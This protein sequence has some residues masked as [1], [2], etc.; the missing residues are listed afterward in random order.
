MEFD[1][2]LKER[3]SIRRF[4]K[5]E[6]PWYLLAECLAAAIEAPSAGNSQNWR[7]IVVR[8]SS[9]R[10]KLTKCCEE[11][12]WLIKAPVL[13]VVCSDTNKIRR[14]FGVRGEAL[15]SVQNCA[16]AIENMLLKGAELGLGSV[17]IGAFDEIKVRELLDIDPDVRPQAIIALGY[18]EEFEE[19]A[20]REPLEN[21]VFFEKWG[22]KEDKERGKLLPV[23]D[24]ISKSLGKVVEKYKK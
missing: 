12:Y 3:K 19:K 2:V 1:K 14:L 5:L 17:W 8:E 23:I 24:R 9:R 13:V 18:G 10:E 11:Q 21:V 7:F 4:K 20:R 15:Y 22:G 16:A 6:V